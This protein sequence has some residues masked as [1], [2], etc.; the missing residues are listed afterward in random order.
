M[1]KAELWYHD[2]NEVDPKH[3][4]LKNSPSLISSCDRKHYD[5]CSYSKVL[6]L[7]EYTR[8]DFILT[9]DGEPVLSVEVTTEV[10]TGHNLPQRYACLLRAAELG[11]PS[12]YYYPEYSRKTTGISDKTLYLNVRTPLAQ[13]RMGKIF[14]VPLLSMFWPTDSVTNFPTTD[15]TKHAQLARL[16][17]YTKR[18]YDTTGGKLKLSDPEVIKITEEMEKKSVPIKPSS[19]GVNASYRSVFPEGNAF[20]SGIAGKSID[21][22]RSCR[23]ESTKSLLHVLYGAEKRC[24]HLPMV[25]LIEY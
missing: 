8:P 20:T 7:V 17:E 4:W 2:P 19:Y 14:D 23:V 21:P 10:P 25:S 9:I 6:A 3:S 12:L 13:L 5:D 1:G 16:V 22:P 18:L 24:H 15:I 11:V